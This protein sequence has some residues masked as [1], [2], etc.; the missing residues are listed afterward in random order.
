MIEFI[1]YYI[2]LYIPT[3]TK[4][5]KSIK[6]NELEIPQFFDV[7]VVSLNHTYYSFACIQSMFE[8]WLLG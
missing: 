6:L 1:V 4:P 3:S 7:I 2:L 8:G 5:N